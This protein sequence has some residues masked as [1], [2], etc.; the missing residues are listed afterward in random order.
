[1]VPHGRGSLAAGFHLCPFTPLDLS[2]WGLKAVASKWQCIK[3]SNVLTMY[4]SSG[5]E[6]VPELVASPLE[7][8]KG[9][10]LFGWGEVAPTH[11][12]VTVPSRDLGI[13]Q[14]LLMG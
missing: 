14:A 8:A 12:S 3:V 7:R 10:Q 2:L 1:M 9:W 4:P 6:W 5:A 11:L 13:Q